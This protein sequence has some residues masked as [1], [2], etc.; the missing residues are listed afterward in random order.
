MGYFAVLLIAFGLA[1]DAL[2]VSVTNGIITADYKR[3]YGLKQGMF[4]GVFQFIMPLIGF[5]LGNGFESLIKSFD[6]WVAFGLLFVIGAN[7]IIETF[8]E[9]EIRGMGKSAA[10]VFSVKNLTLQA[11]ATSIDALAVG[12]SFAVA[13]EGN[14]FISSLIIGAVAFL[15]SYC[16]GMFGVKIGGL[17]QKSASRVGGVILIAIGIKILVEHMLG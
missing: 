1:M 14:I 9:E 17:F 11:V 4:F 8:K 12:I 15:L 7:M 16:G 10:D 2:A 6:H 5:A 13:G 3:Q